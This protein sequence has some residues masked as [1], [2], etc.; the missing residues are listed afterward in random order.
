MLAK[1]LHQRPEN[2]PNEIYKPYL[3]RF[4]AFKTPNLRLE[5]GGGG[6]RPPPTPLIG[7][8]THKQIDS[9][10]TILPG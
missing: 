8:N 3:E 10:L 9:V 5:G 4:Y 1:K 2:G 7:F 6:L